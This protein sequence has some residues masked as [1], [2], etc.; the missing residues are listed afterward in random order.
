[1]GEKK[2]AQCEGPA[3]AEE[4]ADEQLGKVG[5][6]KI[7][8]GDILYEKD[9]VT[10]YYTGENLDVAFRCQRCKRPVRHVGGDTPEDLVFRCDW[11]GMDFP[12]TKLNQYLEMGYWLRYR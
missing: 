4:L 1:M 3:E 6:G 9:G 5:G 10:Y 11:C 12:T 8:P 2:A 7:R